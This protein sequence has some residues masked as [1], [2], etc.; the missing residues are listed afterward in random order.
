MAKSL[1]V[2]VQPEP[3]EVLQARYPLAL[4]HIYD[5]GDIMRGAIRPGEIAAQCFDFQDGIRLLISRERF[6]DGKVHLH[7]SASFAAEC[8]L[9]STLRNLKAK[10]ASGEALR[11]HFLDTAVHR[12]QQLS[13]HVGV[14]FFVGWSKDNVPHW[15][16]DET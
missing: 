2:P 13:G 8:D 9:A 11:Q 6:H 14:L 3:L 4:E 12:F 7:L 15:G 10:G 1:P 5:V 16:A